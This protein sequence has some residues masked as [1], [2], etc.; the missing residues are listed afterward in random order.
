MALNKIGSKGY[1]DQPDILLVYPRSPNINRDAEQHLLVQKLV[2]EIWQGTD[3]ANHILL[4][5]SDNH[6][7]LF[8]EGYCVPALEYHSIGLNRLVVKPTIP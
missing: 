7:L 2:E 1:D 4:L 8:E 6:G 3:F 5:A